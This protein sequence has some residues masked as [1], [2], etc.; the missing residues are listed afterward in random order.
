MYD[1]DNETDADADAEKTGDFK[2]IN[3]QGA[4]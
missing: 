1:L 2:F 4:A 3:V